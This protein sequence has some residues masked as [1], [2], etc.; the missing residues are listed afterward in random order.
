MENL[1]TEEKQKVTKEQFMDVWSKMCS[2]DTMKINQFENGGPANEPYHS[3]MV[4][5]GP[6]KNSEMIHFDILL[7]FL[8][9]D[10]KSDQGMYSCEAKVIFDNYI[11][12]Q[13]LELEQDEYE[14]MVSLFVEAQTKAMLKRK[15]EVVSE[16]EKDLESFLSEI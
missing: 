1:Q 2:D 9:K 8:G 6:I 5:K 14:K 3:I 15:N 7:R 12:Y 10:E 13:N 11:E 4:Y 16:R